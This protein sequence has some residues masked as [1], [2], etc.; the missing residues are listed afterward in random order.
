MLYILLFVLFQCGN[1]SDLIENMQGTC[2]NDITWSFDA[3]TNRLN[4]TGNGEMYDRMEEWDDIRQSVKTIDL[5]YGI[6]S[7]SQLIDINT[8]KAGCEMYINALDDFEK[9]GE[10]VVLAAEKCDK[11]QKISINGLEIRGFSH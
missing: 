7:K 5:S 3:E 10:N 1:A 2:G 9:S 6:T 4:I 8:I 11:K